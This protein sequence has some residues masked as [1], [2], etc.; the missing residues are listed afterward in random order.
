MEVLCMPLHVSKE[1]NSRNYF[2]KYDFLLFENCDDPPKIYYN[3]YGYVYVCVY[4]YYIYNIHKRA[5]A[6]ML[7]LHS[8]F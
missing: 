8:I 1:E 3:T 4:I 5:I 2:L 7:L 6:P